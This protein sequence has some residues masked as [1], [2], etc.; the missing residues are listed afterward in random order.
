M[1]T[2]KKQNAKTTSVTVQPERASFV[3]YVNLTLTSDDKGDYEA[4]SQ[5][6]DVV[7]EQYL[8][9]LELGYQFSIKYDLASEAFICSCSQFRLARPD[10]GLIYTARSAHPFSALHK[11]VYVV[12]RKLA[13]NLAN[14]YVA[15]PNK[16][17]F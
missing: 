1:S 12:S 3:G 15:R 9:A 7:E 11:A 16:D 5:E 10:S 14:G 8:S 4:W 6:S 17:A 2:G 13:F